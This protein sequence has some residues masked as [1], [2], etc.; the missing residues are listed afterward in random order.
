[1][2]A[3]PSLSAGLTASDGRALPALSFG[4]W[5]IFTRMHFAELCDQLVRTAEA[6]QAFYDIANYDGATPRGDSISHTDI[7][8]GRA[9]T[10]AGLS[11]GDFLVQAKVWLIDFPNTSIAAQLD[12]LALRTGLDYLDFINVGMFQMVDDLPLDVLLAQIDDAYRAG[13]I[14]G[15]GVT[16]WAP[17]VVADAYDRAV[18][19]GMVLPSLVQLKYGPARRA[20]AE[21]APFTEIFDRT[22]IRMQSS[23]TLE[24]GYL[25]GK[26]PER[27]IATDPGGVRERILGDVP[28]FHEVAAQF[29]VA[30]A[31]L[32]YAFALTHPFVGNTLTGVRGL[33][34]LEDALAAVPLA[35]SSAAEIREQLAFMYADDGAVDVSAWS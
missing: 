8:F 22:G 15:W 28:R 33:T 7:V 21:G 34:Q 13:R 1:M 5:Q 25:V 3:L 27:K 11:R 23:D 24:G 19:R 9:V 35:A 2:T 12:T 29:G 32:G 26:T 20:V 31:T 18:A 16:G 30:P 10:A 6:G 17:A 4:S 14:G